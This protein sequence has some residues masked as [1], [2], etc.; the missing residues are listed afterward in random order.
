M[1]IHLRVL[2]GDREALVSQLIFDDALSDLIFDGHPDYPSDGR[3]R[4]RNTQD[5]IARSQDLAALTFDV[6]KLE[7]GVLQASFTLGFRSNS[8]AEVAHAPQVS[9]S[10][11]SQFP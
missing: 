4:V 9:S 10:T 11:R 3:R 1:H 8:P 2:D 5:G 6:E 7:G